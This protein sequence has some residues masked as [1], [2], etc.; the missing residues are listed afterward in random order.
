MA[1]VQNSN[2]TIL[3]AA[4]LPTRSR[5]SEKKQGDHELG[6][7]AAVPQSTDFLSSDSEGDE[8]LLEEPIDEQEIYGMP[9]DLSF[10]FFFRILCYFP[11][12]T[13][14]PFFIVFWSYLHWPP[15]RARADPLGGPH[16]DEMHRLR[17]LS[18]AALP[19]R[20]RHPPVF[21][22]ITLQ[23]DQSIHSA[24]WLASPPPSF[25]PFSPLIY[26]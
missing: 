20:L 26:L 22:I 12:P 16:R 8:D 21:A 5:S 24:H 3:S 7:F 11:S 18:H 23:V 14:S 13:S 10:F 15:L 1:E 9:P 4:D 19:A 6:I 2:P 17:L 25:L